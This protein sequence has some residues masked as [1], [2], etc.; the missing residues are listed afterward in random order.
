MAE[1]SR[2]SSDVTKRYRAWYWVLT[3]L[4]WVLILGP[5]GSYVVY[6]FVT[7]EIFGKLSLGISVVAALALLAFG[8]IFKK[9][10]K[11]T[12]FI[13]LLGIYVARR[14]ISL[15]LWLL[16]VCALVDE[17]IIVPLQKSVKKK[18]EINRQIDRRVGDV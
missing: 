3:F 14:E 13:V 10:I 4:S 11:S 8:C 5:L 15:L 9:H 16:I 17:F 6:G 18:Y 12:V 7:S 2:S 1:K